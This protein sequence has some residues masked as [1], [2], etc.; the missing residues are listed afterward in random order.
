MPS[1]GREEKHEARISKHETTE[2]KANNQD[3]P[4]GFAMRD[5]GGVKGQ[6]K[7]QTIANDQ[8]VMTKRGRD[9]TPPRFLRLTPRA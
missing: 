2:Q 4:I 6:H 5:A 7:I 8:I 9:G 3:I 1:E